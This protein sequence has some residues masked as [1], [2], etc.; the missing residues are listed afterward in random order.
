VVGSCGSDEKVRWLLD[1]LKVDTA[2]NYKKI[3]EN[4]ISSE[5]KSMC[6]SWI[7]LYFDNVGG[8]HLEAAIDNMNTFGRIVFCG[9]TSQ[10]NNNNSTAHPTSSGISNLSFCILV[11]C[12]RSLKGNRINGQ[13]E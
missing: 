3:G 2:F 6:P 13:L 4:N 10:Y 5:L 8:K 12:S 1:D 7:N 11:P 9:T